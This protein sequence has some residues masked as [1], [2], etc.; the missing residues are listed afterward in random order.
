M[1]LC[2]YM[3]IMAVGLFM[4]KEFFNAPYDSAEFSEKFLPFMASLAVL[5]LCYGLKNRKELTLFMKNK[6]SY[7]VSSILSIPVIGF[8]IYSI[9]GGFSLNLAFFILIVDTALI[10]IAEEGM[11]RGILLGAMTKRMHP[12]FAILL[13]SLL[14]SLLHGLNLLGGLTVSDVMSQ[15]GATFIMGV[16]LGAMYLD[17]KNIVLPIVFHA[18]W[19]YIL[20]SGSVEEIPFI[21]VLLIFIYVVEIIVSL[22]IMAKLTRK[23]KR[24]KAT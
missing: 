18:L 2:I 15:M 14:F 11:Y 10:G 17:T 19:D 13:S 3:I 12:V 23:E 22:I 16:F 9:I 5:V 1:L 7:V 20:L 8:G 24:L 21:H 4:C 6:P